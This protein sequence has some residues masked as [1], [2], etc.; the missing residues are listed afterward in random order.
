MNGR[1]FFDR[2]IKARNTHERDSLIMEL[3]YHQA[4][5]VSAYRDFLGLLGMDPNSIKNP[6]EIPFMPVEL[7]RTHPITD[8]G[9]SYDKVFESSS[10]TGKGVSRHYV[11]D[12]EVYVRSFSE[13]FR[14]FYGDINSYVLL[15]LLPSYLERQNSSLVYMANRL[16]EDTGSEESG[17]FLD[18]YVLLNNKIRRLV[19]LNQKTILLGVSFAL[20]DFF[21]EYP[22]ILPENFVVMETG[23]MKGRKKEMV[24]DELHSLLMQNTGLNKI[25]SEY[26]MTEI[27]SQAYS[28]GGGRFFSPPWMKISISEINAPGFEVSQGNSGRVR[29]MDLANVH[30]CAFLCTQDVG[31][32][33]EDGSFEVL[34]RLDH[35]EMRG[36]SL[37]AI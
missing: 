3:F 23:G 8:G 22:Q 31:R 14:I 7:F 27:L 25:H 4:K 21:S 12:Q 9:D 19:S 36:C 5:S 13:C 26:G 10:T 29:I 15:A 6:H 24:R 17:F 37:M 18:D 1:I 11:R 35:S 33:N 28:A 32:M 20:V 2:V 34:G 16:I 30:S